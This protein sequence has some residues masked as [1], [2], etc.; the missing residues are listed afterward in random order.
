M[1]DKIIELVNNSDIDN[2]SELL[3][4]L[5]QSKAPKTFSL[6][7]ILNNE[8]FADLKKQIISFKDSEIGKVRTKWEQ[9]IK[10][11][12]PGKKEIPV[13]GESN[14]VLEYL[15]S[16]K[17]EIEGLKIERTKEQKIN[18]LKTEAEN[19]TKDLTEHSKKLIFNQ[20]NENTTPE[21]LSNLVNTYNELE[22]SFKVSLKPGAGVAGESST[23]E[24][25]LAK[26]FAKGKAET[27]KTVNK[28]IK[29]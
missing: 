2:K 21:T 14:E 3:D 4:F 5:E 13:N 23:S 8:E 12:E 11:E 25:E 29:E 28:L 1:F 16:L 17:T 20:I 10:K 18:Q 6:D 7:D 15:K 19:L 22:K 27:P 9:E 26:Q 24:L